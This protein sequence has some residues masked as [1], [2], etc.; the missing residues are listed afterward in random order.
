MSGAGA[1]VTLA[2][3]AHMPVTDTQVVTWLA[4]G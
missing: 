4:F 3:H 2:Q 1:T